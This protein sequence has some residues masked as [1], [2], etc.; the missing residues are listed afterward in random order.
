MYI[1]LAVLVLTVIVLFEEKINRMDF[2][3]ELSD[4]L[5]LI[6]LGWIIIHA[7]GDWIKNQRKKLRRT[8]K[9]LGIPNRYYQEPPLF[10]MGFLQDVARHREQKESAK[11]KYGELYEKAV[12]EKPEDF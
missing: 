2:N 8:P 7:N 5:I 1:N 9:I 4:W 3:L 10:S 11:K 12:G 6:S